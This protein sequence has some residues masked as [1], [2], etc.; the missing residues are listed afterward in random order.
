MKPYHWYKTTPIET[1]N[2]RGNNHA[3]SSKINFTIEDKYYLLS[4]FTKA[5]LHTSNFFNVGPLLLT[6]VNFNPAIDK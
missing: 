1:Q 3:I 6:W 4:L 5:G 2:Y